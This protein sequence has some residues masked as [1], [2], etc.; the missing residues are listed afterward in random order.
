MALWNFR[1]MENDDNMIHRASI[2]PSVLR[3]SWCSSIR[4]SA[5][6]MGADWSSYGVCPSWG[7][8]VSSVVWIGHMGRSYVGASTGAYGVRLAF[9]CKPRVVVVVLN[10]FRSFGIR[11]ISRAVGGVRMTLITVH[12]KKKYEKCSMLYCCLRVCWLFG[13]HSDN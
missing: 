9:P 2:R 6:G 1:S 11:L 7:L 3:R 12:Q 13:G 4:G 10:G 8:G 5:S